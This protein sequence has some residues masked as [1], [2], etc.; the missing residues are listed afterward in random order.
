ME[1]FF[2]PISHFN[3][4]GFR[5]MVITFGMQ[6][7]VNQQIEDHFLSRIT[8][9]IGVVFCPVA[10]NNNV[11]EGLAVFAYGQSSLFW[12]NDRTFV[13]LS[14][15]R[16]LKFRSAISSAFTTAMERAAEGS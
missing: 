15:P 10:A 2:H 16:Y 9:A 12:A 7:P 13:V 14:L 1:N 4:V 11:A 6:H 3:G 5:L 8:K